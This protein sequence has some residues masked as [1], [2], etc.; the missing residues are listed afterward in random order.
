MILKAV[1]RRRILAS[2]LFL[3]VLVA[4]AVAFV[5]LPATYESEASAVFLASKNGSKMAGDNPYMAFNATLN[6]AADVVRYETMDARTVSFLAA[7]GY[8][9]TYLITDA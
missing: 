2:I 5:K 3:I 7:H 8:T 6:E 1:R 4:T 9:A